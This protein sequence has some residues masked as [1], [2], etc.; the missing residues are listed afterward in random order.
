MFAWLLLILAVIAGALGGL[1]VRDA[2][3]VFQ[4]IAGLVAFVCSSVLLSGAF[5]VNA[6]NVN[7]RRISSEIRELA[8]TIRGADHARELGRR[9]S[10]MADQRSQ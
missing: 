7:R 10:G 3:T 8:K 1:I 5:I 9:L 4:Q 6:V 2:T